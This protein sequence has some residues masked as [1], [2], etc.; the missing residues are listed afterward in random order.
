MRHGG[1]FVT[2]VAFLA[3]SGTA[4]AADPVIMEPTPVTPVVSVYDWTGPYI[5]I[6]GGYGWAR[7]DT[8]D[9]DLFQSG[10]SIDLDGFFLGGYAGYNVQW[11]QFVFGIEG[12]INKSWI[13]EGFV[14]GGG[15]SGSAEIDWFGS[16]R[17]R[18]G[19]AWD[20][21]LLFATGGIAFASVDVDIPIRAGSDSDS[22]VG[23][24]VGAGLE[25][26]FT[27][28]WLGRVEYRYYD[29]GDVTFFPEV[30]GGANLDL[31]MHTVSVGLSYKF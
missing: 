30:D 11:N 4:W 7:M 21:T 26:A 13:D 10:N 27:E 8:D 20:R 25:H 19:H 12:D 17:G 23:W 28:N 31:T 29:F 9:E 18:V 22:P 1:A 24:T 5:G 15:F 16:L 14:T 2:S 3:F 6:Q